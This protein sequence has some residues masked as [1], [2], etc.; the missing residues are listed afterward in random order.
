MDILTGIFTFLLTW[1]FLRILLG[2]PGK[3]NY[4]NLAFESRF[5][6]IVDIKVEQIGTQIYLWDKANDDFLAQ[7]KNIEEALDRCHER[8]PNKKFNITNLVQHEV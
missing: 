5:E 3:G 2:T 1:L 6:G 8:Y 4:D 7:G